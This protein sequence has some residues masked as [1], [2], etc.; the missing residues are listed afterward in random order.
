MSFG[1]AGRQRS[2]QKPEEIVHNADVAVYQA[3]HA[4]RNRACL[5]SQDGQDGPG[6][7]KEPGGTANAILC[8]KR[9][10]Y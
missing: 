5:F 10:K 7:K 4:G 1:L 6:A 3:K 2:G 8:D 9:E